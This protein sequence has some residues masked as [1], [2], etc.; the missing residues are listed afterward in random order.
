MA[1]KQMIDVMGLPAFPGSAPGDQLPDVSV[2]TQPITVPVGDQVGSHLLP[3]VNVITQPITVPVG[4]QV[5]S[6]LLPDVSVITQPITVVCTIPA[7]SVA[8]QLITF[9]SSPLVT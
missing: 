5:G 4:D 7:V 9:F 2:V 8:T 6:H 3:D 1:E